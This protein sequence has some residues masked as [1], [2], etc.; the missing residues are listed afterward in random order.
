MNVTYGS[1]AFMV[2]YE[3]AYALSE[4][5]AEV[6]A[7]AGVSTVVTISDMDQVLGD[8]AGNAVEVAEAVDFLTGN[9]RE[10]RLGEITLAL[11]AEMLML[12]GLAKDAPARAGLVPEET[13]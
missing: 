6:A 5:I 13:R 10:S 7:G 3:D 2:T 12:G 11:T 9:D 4:S 1:G 8:A